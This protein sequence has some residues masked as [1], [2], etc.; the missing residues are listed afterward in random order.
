[1]ANGKLIGSGF[2][3]FYAIVAR[4]DRESVRRANVMKGRPVDQVGSVTVP[5][6]G[7]PELFD[8]SQLPARLARRSVLTVIDTFFGMGPFGFRGPAAGHL[9]PHLTFPDEGVLT[10]QVIAPGYAC[11]SNEFIT[12]CLNATGDDLLYVTSANRSRHLTGADDTPAH[13]RSAALREEF[14]NEPDFEILEHADED[15]VRL[16]YPQH[17]P[18]STTILGF[19]RLGSESD[20]SRPQLVLDRHGSLHV[21]VVRKVLDQLGFGLAIGPHAHAR[22]Q[23]RNYPATPLC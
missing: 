15:A 2:A 18:M 7:V 4:A 14:G 11:P 10:T 20:D 21:D 13:W 5:P 9:A 16:A 6:S 1:L 3:N 23:L 19:H 22:L 17:L 12:R 8:W